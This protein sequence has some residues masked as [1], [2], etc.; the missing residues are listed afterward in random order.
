M[1]KYQKFILERTLCFVSKDMEA[2][3]KQTVTN[4]L[5]D[6]DEFVVQQD[7]NYNVK[8]HNI[9]IGSN[10]ASVEIDGEKCKIIDTPHHSFFDSK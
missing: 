10:I 3:D 5:N 8:K 6:K 9:I 4:F 2:K 1:N 7:E